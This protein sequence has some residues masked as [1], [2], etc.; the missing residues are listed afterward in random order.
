VA[1]ATVRTEI[2]VALDVDRTSRRQIALD[3]YAVDDATQPD[4]ILLGKIV[5]FDVEADA[6]LVQHLTR[7]TAADTRRCT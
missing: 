6:G 3:L 1:H 2:N 5:G 7:G 4:Q